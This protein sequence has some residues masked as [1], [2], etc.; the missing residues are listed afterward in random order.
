[1]LS[2]VDTSGFLPQRNKPLRNIIKDRQ[3]NLWVTAFDDNNFLI[4]F[5]EDNIRNYRIKALEN[6]IKWK[7]TIVSLCRDEER[8]FWFFKDVS[9]CAST[10]PRRMR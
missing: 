5:D 8:I 9:D 6:R 3:G 1:M 7:P 2:R 10:M 4:S